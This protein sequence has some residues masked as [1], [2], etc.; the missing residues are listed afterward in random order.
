ML[1]QL[2]SGP[3]SRLGRASSVSLRPLQDLVGIRAL[4]S[5]NATANPVV[6]DV[7]SPASEASQAEVLEERALRPRE[8][9]EHLDRYIIGQADA[10][11]A[12][13]V[14][15][16]NRWRRQRVASPLREEIN[17]KNI[18]MIGPTGV[19]KTEGET[20]DPDHAGHAVWIS[21]PRAPRVGKV[22]FSRSYSPRAPGPACAATR[23]LT[24]PRS[25]TEARQTGQRP[26][27][28]G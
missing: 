10:K 22:D 13:A 18:L 23:G 7:E 2:R 1:R 16:R 20:R 28:Q 15:L 3:V 19:G 14:A 4:S 27:P 21:S 24:L 12:V 9:C 8:I 5:V 6:I 25:R 26:V 17:P 11:R